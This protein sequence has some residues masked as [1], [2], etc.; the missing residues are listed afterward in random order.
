MQALRNHVVTVLLLIAVGAGCT[1]KD[2]ELAKRTNDGTETFKFIA[3]AGPTA[4][5]NSTPSDRKSAPE[6]KQHALTIKDG[7]GSETFKFKQDPRTLPK[8]TKNLGK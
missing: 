1:D 7:D 3:P 5:T 4:S 6:P 2:R 8:S